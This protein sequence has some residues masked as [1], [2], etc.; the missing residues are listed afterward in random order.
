MVKNSSHFTT[1]YLKRMPWVLWRRTYFS[2]CSLPRVVV[3]TSFPP[4]EIPD[5][6]S[7]AWYASWSSGCSFWSFAIV[8]RLLSAVINSEEKGLTG[9]FHPTGIH[10][11]PIRRLKK[12][13]KNRR[14]LPRKGPLMK[15]GIW[16]SVTMSWWTKAEKRMAGENSSTLAKSLFTFS[17]LLCNP[18]PTVTRSNAIVAPAE[19]ESVY[20][21][22]QFL[23]LSWN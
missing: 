11:F 6:S 15:F 9:G 2:V 20:I 8:C 14:C 5:W 22:R 12:K 18:I 17:S 7:L 3:K 1:G 13:K 19:F 16:Q 21:F 4:A 23:R 10:T